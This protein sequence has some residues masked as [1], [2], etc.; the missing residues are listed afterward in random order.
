MGRETGEET[1]RL[2]RQESLEEWRQEEAIRRC[3]GGQ[4]YEHGVSAVLLA[5]LTTCQVGRRC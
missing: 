4:V 2:W 3:H 5:Y 1:T